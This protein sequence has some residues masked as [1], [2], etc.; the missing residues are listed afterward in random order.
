LVLLAEIAEKAE[1]YEDMAKAIEKLV[2][3][4]CETKQPL[5]KKERNF[6]SVAYKKVLGNRRS[7]WRAIDTF[8]QK[9]EGSAFEQ[10]TI[11][12]EKIAEEIRGYCDDVIVGVKLSYIA[13]FVVM[14]CFLNSKWLANCL[15]SLKVLLG[16]EMMT[17]RMSNTYFMS[18]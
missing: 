16:Q 10:A 13:E 18:R 1:L 8:A 2:T 17:Q 9:Q 14:Y 11:Y 4:A 3:I 7:A 5:I 15:R 12:K 6:L